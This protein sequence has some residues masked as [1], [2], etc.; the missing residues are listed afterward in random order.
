M[1]DYKRPLISK[2]TLNTRFH[3]DYEWWRQ[4]DRDWHVYL[5]NIL[6]PEHQQLFGEGLVDQMIDWVDPQTAE[7][8]PVN[9]LQHVLIEHCAKQPEFLA[10]GIPLVDLIFR[11]FLAS[12][13]TPLSPIE[14]SE[15]LGKPAQTILSVLSGSRVYRGLRPVSE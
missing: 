5:Y 15:R 9:G 10:A 8:Q 14:L 1:A 13:N 11:V 2:P 6:C 4:N 3:I 12:G 7:V